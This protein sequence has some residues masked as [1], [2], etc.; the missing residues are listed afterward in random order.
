MFCRRCYAPLNVNE[1]P[2]CPNCGR[3]F[4][5]TKPLTFLQRPFPSGRKM[6]VHLVATT[7]L[8]IVAAYVIALHQAAQM[9]GH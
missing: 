5:P 4:D 1:S 9:S 8:G 2:R 6:V 7:F 3:L